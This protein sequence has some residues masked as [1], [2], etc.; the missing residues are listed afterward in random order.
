MAAITFQYWLFI[1]GGSAVVPQIADTVLLL[2]RSKTENLRREEYLRLKAPN[3]ARPPRCFHT[4]GYVRRAMGTRFAV[5]RDFLCRSLVGVGSE[6][7]IMWSLVPGCRHSN[8]G[9]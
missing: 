3:R 4:F 7:E 1:V 2:M 8:D 6:H 5:R 9:R